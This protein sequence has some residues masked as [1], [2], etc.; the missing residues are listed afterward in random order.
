MVVE[1]KT[2][3]ILGVHMVGPM[4][5][6][7]ITTA[8]YAIANK[9]AVDNIKSIVHVIPTLS[10]AIKKVTHS[11]DGNLDDMACCVE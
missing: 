3:Q 4:S 1:Y 5:V 6:D 11:V 2:R 8:T 7:I 10:E 9:M